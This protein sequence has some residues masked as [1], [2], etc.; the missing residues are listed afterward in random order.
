MDW[1]PPATEPQA[2]LL[3]SAAAAR[4]AGP[5]PAAW[6]LL[7]LFAVGAATA[8]AARAAGFGDVRDGGGTAQAALA[9]V[10]AAGFAAVLHLA[11]EDRTPVTLPAG[12]H[13]ETRIVYRARLQALAGAAEAGAADQDWVLLYSARTARHFA[14]EWDRLGRDRAVVALAVIS[15]AVAAVAGPGWQ[16]LAIAETPD[17]SA[18]FAAAGLTNHPRLCQ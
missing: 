3:T 10:A 16:Q 5:V 17:E 7:P 15:A 13:V 14:A 2:L 9:A 4:L 6:R 11:G 18:L 8:T 12:L 1:Q